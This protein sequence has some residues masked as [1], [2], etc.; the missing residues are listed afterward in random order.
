MCDNIPGAILAV[1]QQHRQ[2]PTTQIN[3][4]PATCPECGSKPHIGGRAHCPAYEQTCHHCN[5]MGH[6]ARVC[7]ARQVYTRPPQPPGPQTP[8]TPSTRSLQMAQIDDTQ[9]SQLSTITQVTTTEPVV[10]V[11]IHQW[12]M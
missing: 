1:R 3:Q 11:S 7:R 2:P 9:L 10:T 6:F 5:K 8:L 12:L 4:H